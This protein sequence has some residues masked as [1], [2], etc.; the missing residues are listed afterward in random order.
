V[1]KPRSSSLETPTARLKLKVRKRPYWAK[2]GPGTWVG[3]RRN[4]GAGTWSARVGNEDGK[5]WEKRIAFADDLE[6]TRPPLVLNYWG[7]IAEV[8]KLGRAD[9]D[10][11][12]DPSKPITLDEALARYE[13]DLRSRSAHA[14]NARHPRRHLT[15]A[16]LSKPVL[17]LSPDDLEKW[18]RRLIEK[19]KL[20]PASINRMINGVRACLELAAPERSHIWQKG[21]QKLPNA[22]RAR[23]LVYPDSVIRRILG[24]ADANDPALGL[25]CA[26]LAETGARAS[27]VQRL[28][29]ED[30]IDGPRPKL[31]VSRSAKGGGRHRA[32][33]KLQRYPVP[34]TPQ[35]AQRLRAAAAGRGDDAPLLLRCNGRPWTAGGPACDYRDSFRKVVADIGLGACTAY[36]FRHSSIVRALLAGISTKLVA[37]LHDTSAAMIEAHYGKYI[38]EHEHADQLARSALLQPEAPA[39]PKVIPIAGR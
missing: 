38:A 2:V 34:I 31:M 39:D 10:A 28:L 32:E 12:E 25:L 7:A 6:P 26:V 22:T 27:Q 19:G 4:Q 5:G 13:T 9:P 3:Y 16:L 35:L 33:R 29:V 36:C 11:P 37:A 24:A 8:Q 15:A 18:C 1:P 23:H 14:Y 21:L 20:K 30:L 17:L